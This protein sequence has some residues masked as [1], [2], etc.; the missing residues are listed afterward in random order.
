MKNPERT[1]KRPLS[2]PVFSGSAQD[3]SAL[4]DVILVTVRFVGL[5]GNRA[6][7]KGNQIAYH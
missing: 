4:L 5:S 7:K 6:K 1:A 2:S 3:I